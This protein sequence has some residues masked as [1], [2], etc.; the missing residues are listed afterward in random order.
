MQGTAHGLA[1][2]QVDIVREALYSRTSGGGRHI[3]TLTCDTIVCEN[4][5]ESSAGITPAVIGIAGATSICSP[6]VVIASLRYEDI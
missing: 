1:V 3:V 4:G 5:T 6:L 2:V